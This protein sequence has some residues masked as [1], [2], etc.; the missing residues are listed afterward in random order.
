MNQIFMK[1]ITY[2]LLLLLVV[3]L[4]LALFVVIK[5]IHKDGFK[6]LNVWDEIQA[7]TNIGVIISIFFVVISFFQTR[8]NQEINIKHSDENIR[9]LYKGLEIDLTRYEYIKWENFIIPE[10][11]NSI[12]FVA[13]KGLNDDDLKCFDIKIIPTFK[14]LKSGIV[15]GRD[16]FNSIVFTY[17]STDPNVLV[18]YTEDAITI[19]IKDFNTSLYNFKTNNNTQ[20]EWLRKELNS[21]YGYFV[22]IKYYPS[23]NKQNRCVVEGT[24]N[25]IKQKTLLKEKDWEWNIND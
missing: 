18:N 16:D 9:L 7:I 25:V 11:N 19:K 17:S 23:L 13:H 5:K 10:E 24:N 2:G 4:L 20:N 6:S 15:S 12:V 3:I 21:L 14:N 1:T 22:E 8:Q